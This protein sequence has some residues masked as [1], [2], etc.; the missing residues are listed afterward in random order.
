MPAAN[1]IPLGILFVV[2]AVAIM[3]LSA[4]IVGVPRAS[5]GKSVLATIGVSLIVGA[6]FTAVTAFG[7]VLA[8]VLSVAALV[9]CL[10]I[11]RT[12]FQITTLPAF[13]ILIVNIMIQM[14]LISLYLRPFVHTVP[15]K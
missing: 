14:I 8:V 15:K 6:V 13:L 2:I 10:W 3:W 5:V 7:P 12:V 1:T 9:G 4:R 11:L